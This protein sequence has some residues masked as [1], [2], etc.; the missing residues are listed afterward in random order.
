MMRW[1][2]IAAFAAASFA[3]DISG[4]WRGT[5]PVG[6]LPV[7]TGGSALRGRTSNPTPGQ[8]VPVLVKISKNRRGDLSGSLFLAENVATNFTLWSIAFSAGKLTFSMQTIGRLASATGD[9][10]FAGTLAG[11]QNSI[12][13]WFE[14]VP[15]ILEREARIASAPAAANAAASEEHAGSAPAADPASAPPG[16]DP[17]AV[18]ARALQKLAG[19]ERRL[20][21]Y[22][23]LETV[24]R[25]YYSEPPVK[26]SQ[27]VMTEAPP[28]SSCDKKEFGRQGH[29][30]LDAEDRLRLEVAVSNG[31]EIH[32][33]PNGSELGA[34][35]V[36]EMV[37]AGPMHTGAIGTTLVDVFE[38]P[39]ATY[40]FAGAGRD[41]SLRFDFQVPAA[42]S[43]YSVGV[44][45]GWKIAAYHGFFELDP[46][47]GDLTRLITEAGELPVASGMC[48]ARTETGYHYAAIGDGQFLLPVQSEFD[49]LTPSANETRSVITYSAC[50]EFTAESSLVSGDQA[51][52]AESKAAVQP[53]APLPA[54]LELTLTLARAIDSATAAA[55]DAIAARVS[56]AVRAAGSNQVV[57]PAG[58]V[59]RGRIL[60]MRRNYRSSEFEVMIR[61]DTLERNGTASPLAIRADRE[62]KTAST[63]DMTKLANRGTEFSLA[64]RSSEPGGWVSVHAEGTRYVMPAG[65]ESKWVTVTP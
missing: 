5:L 45:K 43:H 32:S 50:H 27:N 53:A 31:R 42:A 52:A 2:L 39:G 63:H 22:T 24:E 30:L 37:T 46:V 47:S 65:S 6:V 57:I 64:P 51:A 34:R 20:L 3:Q 40:R 18:L 14:G 29:L 60:Q 1:V 49:T 17:S 61:F 41:G 28:A 9:I 33:W 62:L 21:K 48:R 38:N 35:S 11:D 12:A 58:A 19:T 56:K 13:G 44:G 25:A 7:P 23:C 36:F 10:S 15:L 16:V 55:G 54:G 26:V 4:V 8:N 59:A